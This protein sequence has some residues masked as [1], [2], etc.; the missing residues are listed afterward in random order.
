MTHPPRFRPLAVVVLTAVT[1]ALIA[2]AACGG[3]P[4]QPGDAGAGGDVPGPSGD[5]P[6][7]PP[8]RPAPTD[9]PAPTDSPAPPDGGSGPDDLP[10]GD[11]PGADGPSR[12]DAPPADTGPGDGQGTT[13]TGPPGDATADATS[14]PVD[15][16]MPTRQA[17]TSTFGQDLTRN[18]GR[19]DG[20]LVSLVPDGTSQCNGDPSHLHL[21]VQAQGGIYDV[22]VNLDVLETE[23]DLQLP[24][25]AWTEGWH[26]GVVLDYVQLGLHS[27]DFTSYSQSQLRQMLTDELA[28]VNHISVFATGYGP[29]G[30]HDV[31]RNGG[32]HDGAIVIHPLS[33]PSHL[34]FF[35]FSNQ[36]F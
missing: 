9:G 35:H 23:R 19:L 4:I 29:T 27:G 11:A 20:F 1:A 30:I 13:D 36:T 2:S 12:P 16:G 22:A 5:A 8:D 10:V 33:S 21:Q 34:L 18:F 31:H 24:D 28:Q 17:C 15:D 25:G 14:P 3:S 7:T 26:P 32:G 6:G